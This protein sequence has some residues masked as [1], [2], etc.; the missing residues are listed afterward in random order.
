MSELISPTPEIDALIDRHAPIILCSSGG[1]DSRLVAEQTVAYARAR[2][3]RGDIKLV[4]ADLNT[5]DWMVTWWDARAQCQALADRLGVELVVV[6]RE[7][8]GLM[9]RFQQ[10]AR[11]NRA[12]YCRL[13]MVTALLPFPQPGMGRFCTS[14]LKTGPVQ[15]WVRRN[16]SEPVICVLG[17]RRDEGNANCADGRIIRR[18]S[19]RSKAPV[20][21]FYDG[22]KRTG[23][24]KGSYDWNAVVDVKTERVF[25]IHRASGIALP[26][27]Y[28]VY[29]ATRY[30][31]SCCIF[32]TLAD[33][34]AALRDERNHPAYR[35][36][37]VI[38]IENAFSYQGDRWLCDVAPVLLTPEMREAAQRAKER[39]AERAEVERAVPKHLLF[40]ND[41][42]LH[43][44]PTTQPN[45]Y[46]AT[47][48]A[49]VRRRVAAIQGWA[50]V[51]YTEPRA[52]YDRYAELIAVKAAKNAAKEAAQ[53]RREARALARA[54]V[55]VT[56]GLFDALPEAE[57]EL[58][59]A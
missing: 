52:V 32:S 49:W 29:G 15:R 8:G 38:E 7:Q 21:V 47:L 16:Y 27:A 3:H 40:K 56:P 54:Q 23:L 25:Q 50:E 9:E 31:C 6:A 24:P 35:G 17:I 30:S 59:A 36:L 13:L 19:G 20:A 1:K 57:G 46:E 51:E 22:V 10:R 4:Y 33:L 39:A 26:D 11:D 58:I 28:E 53:R 5:D 45:Y 48:L 42:G 34:R 43:G 44:W 37:C 12:R 41:G 55:L 18:D 2:G 14:E